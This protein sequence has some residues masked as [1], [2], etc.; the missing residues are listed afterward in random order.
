MKVP[1]LNFAYEVHIKLLQ[2]ASY[3]SRKNG[4]EEE[5]TSLAKEEAKLN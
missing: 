1:L 3:L 5:T 2:S 4:T